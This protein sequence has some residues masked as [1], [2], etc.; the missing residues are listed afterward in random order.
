VR[1]TD[2]KGGNDRKWIVGNKRDGDSNILVT[3]DD[4][5]VT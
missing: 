2:R 5:R 3:T 1:Q 4:K